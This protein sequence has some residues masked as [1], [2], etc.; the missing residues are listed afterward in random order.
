ME[1]MTVP[2]S[3]PATPE[4]IWALLRES[5][6]ER[7]RER[8]EAKK[9]AELRREEYDRR[10]E[11]YD[12][13]KEEDQRRREQVE[14]EMQ[15][16]REMQKEIDRSMQETDRCMKETDRRMKETD[17]QMG[18]LHNSFGD[19]AEHLVAPGI[20]ARFNEM[21]YFFGEVSP[22]GRKIYGED[23]KLKA[24][25]DI[26]LENGET[27][28]AVEV[29]AKVV[30]GD[31]EDFLERIQIL[32]EHRTKKNDRR[33]IQG[34]IAGAI[35]GTAQKREVIQAGLYVIEQTGDTMKIDVPEGFVPR[36]W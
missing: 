1:T 8:E 24:E 22:G 15:E 33:K 17:K 19:L 23:G 28:M 26:L 27:V 5:Q 9:E 29:K 16:L 2:N 12:R 6:L 36:E 10:R 18:R 31:I 32:R 21:G 34:A 13:R 35:F 7:Q 4:E 20:H 3:Q 25:I 30:K 11:E 14:R